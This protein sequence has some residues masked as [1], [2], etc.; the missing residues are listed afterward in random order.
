MSGRL[1]AMPCG[2]SSSSHIMQYRRSRSSNSIMCDGIAIGQNWGLGIV[3]GVDS[4]SY[5]GCISDRTD[6]MD[7]EDD[8]GAAEA[9]ALSIAFWKA[10]KN[11]NTGA[12]SITI[13]VDRPSCIRSLEKRQISGTPNKRASFDRCLTLLNHYCNKALDRYQSIEIK[14]LSLYGLD[15]KW[16]PDGHARKALVTQS[17]G[18]KLPDVLRRECVQ[19]SYHRWNTDGLLMSVMLTRTSP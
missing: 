10:S 2:V 17:D 4:I 5:G 7:T 8:I 15:R 12:K 1:G 11:E 18:L 6:F 19:F 9:L 13:I 16:A 3:Q 14:H